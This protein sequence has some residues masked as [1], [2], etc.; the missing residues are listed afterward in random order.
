MENL[1]KRIKITETVSEDGDYGVV[2][3][4]K[5]IMENQLVIMKTLM[6]IKEELDE[7]P[8]KLPSGC[9]PG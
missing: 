4:Q 9:G 5:I 3:G 2:Y 1:K 8:K 6:E 7:M